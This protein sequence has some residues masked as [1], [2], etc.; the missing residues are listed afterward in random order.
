MGRF[1]FREDVSIADCAIEVWGDSLGDLLEISARAL[2][3]LMAEPG[4]IAERERRPVRLIA[5]S[6]ELLLF[7][8]IGEILFLKDRDRVILPRAEVRVN[9]TRPLELVATLFG[10]VVDPGRT[11]RNVDVKAI[12]MHE[13]RVAREGKEWHGHF[14]VDL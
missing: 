14:V 5:E 13:L 10:D 4:A 3:E 9:E 1:H 8:W 2:S 12:T 11:R 7:D 6:E